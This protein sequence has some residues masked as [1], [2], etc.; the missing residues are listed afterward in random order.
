MKKI[1]FTLMACVLCLGLVGG[2]FA[3][4]TDV[5]SS[6]GNNMSAGTLN[7]QIAQDGGGW[8]DSP[9]VAGFSSPVGL[10]PGDS[11]ATIPI[12]I[13]NVGTIPIQRVYAR[14][15]NLTYG[16][17]AEPESEG[18]GTVNDIGTKI[19]ILWYAEQLDGGPN[20]WQ[21]ESFV[22]GSHRDGVGRHVPTQRHDFRF[23]AP[24]TVMVL[25]L[26]TNYGVRNLEVVQDHYILHVDGGNVGTLLPIT[27][28]G[29]TGS[30]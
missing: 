1:L 18:V 10:A 29:F 25:S 24:I 12:Y 2:A 26:W 5:E 28:V 20:N 9:V 19:K 7:M 15:S 6:T 11:W 17:G 16:D 23:A 21:Y 27:M 30:S 22:E 3:Y 13:K 4:F 8:T 14:F